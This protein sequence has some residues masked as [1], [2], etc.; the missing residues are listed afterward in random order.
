MMTDLNHWLALLDLP[1]LLGQ[2]LLTVVLSFTIGLELHSY[3]KKNKQDLGFGTTRTF[4]LLGVLG[5]ILFVLDD[6]PWLYALGLLALMLFLTVFYTNRVKTQMPSMLGMLLA[7]L[8]YILPAVVLSY[9]TWF[10][11]LYVVILLLLMGEKSSIRRFS[12][13]FHSDEMVTFSKYLIMIGV[14]LP[15]LPAREIYAP[16]ITVTFYQV[17]LAL[18]VVSSVSYLSYLMQ[19]YVFREKGLLFA[20]I[21]GGLYSST[22]TTVVLARR[23][24]ESGA[25]PR[26]TIA[27]IIATVMMYL[28]LL[29]LIFFLGHVEEAE[30]LMMPFMVMVLLSLI[31]V[32]LIRKFGQFHHLVLGETPIRHPLEFRT[33]VIFAL[34]FVLFAALTKLMLQDF[35]QSGLTMMSLLVGLVDTDPFIL[36]LLA[37]KFSLATDAITGAILIATASNNMLKAV[38]A[39]VMG[40]NRAC[41]H[42][43]LWLMATALM[44]FSYA[45]VEFLQ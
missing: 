33:A 42:A 34:M 10:S 37:G 13:A 3:R 23:S 17:W 4:T 40:R 11:I 21:L 43:A 44:T 35:G 30:R 41:T 45:A 22:A 5:F 29:L 28:R 38:Y 12:D 27:I 36:S 31:V 24:Q 1:T 32:G 18:L 8:T 14:V 2:F 20:G 16:Y 7:L 25:D 15:L 39:F 26:M 9:P 19:T 6:S